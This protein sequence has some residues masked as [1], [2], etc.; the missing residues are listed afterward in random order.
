MEDPIAF[1]LISKEGN[2]RYEI[3]AASAALY[4]RTIPLFFAFEGGG[5]RTKVGG[6]IYEGVDAGNNVKVFIETVK[7][8]LKNKI[9]T[10]F[11]LRESNQNPQI[12]ED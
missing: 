4:G 12:F 8:Y 7:N 1:V 9:H 3:Q 5:G 11:L 10:D 6:T 2:E